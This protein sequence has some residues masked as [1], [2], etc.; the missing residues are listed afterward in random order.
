VQTQSIAS[1]RAEITTLDA[2]L[3][4]MEKATKPGLEDDRRFDAVAKAWEAACDSLLVL[5]PTTDCE[6]AALA[7]TLRERSLPLYYDGGKLDERDQALVNLTDAIV[8]RLAA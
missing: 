2:Q 7:A 3:R 6:I 4:E 8:Q 1:L 5:K